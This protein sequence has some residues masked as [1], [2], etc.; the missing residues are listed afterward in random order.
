MAEETVQNAAVGELSADMMMDDILKEFL[1]EANE[2]L[3]RLELDF[4]TLEKEPGNTELLNNIFRVFHSMK[5]ASSFMG[6]K[7]LERTSHKTEDV[8]NKLRKFELTLSSRIMDTLLN[9]VDVIKLILKDI[10]ENKTD[11]T[12]NTDDITARLEDL[13]REDSGPAAKEVDPG[14]EKQ[15]PAA[16]KNATAEVCPQNDAPA[17][18]LPAAPKSQTTAPDT[19][20]QKEDIRSIRINVEKLDALFNLVGELVLS[21]NR[22]LQLHRILSRKYPD[23]ETINFDLTEAGGYIN[24]LTTEIQLAVMKTRMMPVSTVFNKF[25]RIVRDIAKKMNKEIELF[26]AGDDTEIDKNIVE[27]IGD[28]LTHLIRNSADHGIEP[29]DEREKIGKQRMGRIDLKAYYEGNYVVISIKDDGRGIDIEAVKR[30]AVEKKMVTEA[31]ANK[32]SK[33]A[34]FD[35]IF[36][37]GFSTAK[38][39]SETSGRGVG[40]DVVKTNI[41][42][43]RGQIV[44]D[45]VLGAGTEIKM[46]IPL[47]LAIL[48]TLIVSISDQRYTVPLSNVLET[49]RIRYGDMEMLRGSRIFRMRDELMPLVL[50]SEL[51]DLSY[52]YDNDAEVTI[53]VLKHGTLRMGLVVDRTSGQEEV[54]IKPLNCLEGIAEPQALSGATILGDGSITF[55]LDVDALM[56]MSKAAERQ[57]DAEGAGRKEAKQVETN[58]I[59]V[60]LVDNLDNEQYAIP[61]R[62]I[63]EIEI[64]QKTDIEEIGGRPMVKYRGRITPLITIPS[65]TG[66]PAQNEF[67]QYYMV[68]LTDNGR[69]AGLLVGRLLG[70]N[71]MEEAL[72]NRDENILRGTTGSAIFNGRITFLLDVKEMITE[73]S[74]I[75]CGNAR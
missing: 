59:N 66:I 46:K 43:L 61:A 65:I 49:H 54:V 12:I 33:Q 27:G 48:D 26:V 7:N 22:N 53:V 18:I 74:S 45:S 63:K 1:A 42:K 35:F 58:T 11:S 24:H 19:Q 47:T 40:M 10:E 67:E 55:I 31:E 28:P 70:I 3:Q 34:L 75:M 57:M 52:K 5:G 56:K 15:A 60:V 32:L 69:E 68:I 21:R 30:K 25:R 8:L 73:T 14:T 51:F 20:P 44:M 4:I 13:I 41:D 6:L 72:I 17:A 71:R 29:P 38:T 2:G 50:L 62:K 39:V 37:P 9:A 36:A 16:A 64:I 23:D